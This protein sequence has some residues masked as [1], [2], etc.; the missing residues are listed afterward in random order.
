MLG[1]ELKQSAQQYRG[2]CPAC[3]SDSD[4]AWVVTPGKQ[5]FYCFTAASGGD[6][7]ALVAH[8]L[9]CDMKAAAQFIVDRGST[10]PDKP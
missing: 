6:L 10:A 3:E 5:A 1:L 8:I 7:I 4:R 2:A 9:G